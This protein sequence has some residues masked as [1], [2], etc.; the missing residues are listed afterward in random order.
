MKEFKSLADFS[1]FTKLALPV[2]LVGELKHGLEKCAKAI[3]ETAK[4]EIGTYQPAV[5]PFQDWEQLADSTVAQRERLGFT[6]NDPLL[7]TGELR[8]SIERQVHNLEAVIG[9]KS[10]IAAYQEF[11]TDKIPPRPFLG[12]AVIHNRKKIERIVGEAAVSG[13][14]GGHRVHPSLGYDM[15][16]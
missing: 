13:L 7:R 5:G 16:I 2:L 9:S 8:G 10:D 1:A 14:A 4:A 6:P 15:D 11:G 3:E 12:P